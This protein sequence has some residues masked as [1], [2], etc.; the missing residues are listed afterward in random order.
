MERST[1]AW[2]IAAV[3]AGTVLFASPA[4]AAAQS[5]ES[6]PTVV[7]QGNIWDLVPFGEG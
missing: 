4:T 3:M 5:P 6:A 1:A 7:R 2:A